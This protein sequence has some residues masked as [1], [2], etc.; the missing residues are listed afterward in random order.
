MI[1]NFNNPYLA[2]GLGEFWTR[3]H[4]SLSTLVPAI[5]STSALGGSYKRGMFWLYSNLFIT[6]LISGV[7][8]GS[9]WKYAIWGAL[10]AVGVIVTRELERSASYRELRSGQRQTRKKHVS[11]A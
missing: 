3:W 1:L 4:I 8:H 9:A 2:S 10:H 7:W 11:F 6:F 5:T